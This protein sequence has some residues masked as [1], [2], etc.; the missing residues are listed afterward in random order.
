MIE[1]TLIAPSQIARGGKPRGDGEGM[2]QMD[3]RRPPHNEGEAMPRGTPGRGPVGAGGGP[4][5]VPMGPPGSIVI[6]PEPPVTFTDDWF[7]AE[8]H[9]PK[10]TTQP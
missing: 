8:H 1:T 4:G 5:N 2:G 7:T 10:A 3:G 6:V 9:A